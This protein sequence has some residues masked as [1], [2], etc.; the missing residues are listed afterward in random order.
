MPAPVKHQV[1]PLVGPKD[2][3]MTI[4]A[5]FVCNNGVL[6]CADSEHTD[7]ATKSNSAKVNTF[8]FEGGSVGYAYAG[9]DSLAISAIQTCQDKL[10]TCVDPK[11][12]V[13]ILRGA[14]EGEYRKHVLSHPSYSASSE[15]SYSLLLSVRNQDGVSL[16]RSHETALQKIE[17][18]DCIGVGAPFAR[19]LIQPNFAYRPPED[20]VLALAV[21]ALKLTKE[22]VPGCGGMSVFQMMK[23]DGCM[24]WITSESS[25][26]KPVEDF[27]E[28]YD[29]MSRELFIAMAD[30]N[31]DQEIFE[32]HLRERF[33]KRL[34]QIRKKW[35]DRKVRPGD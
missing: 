2:K 10:A 25:R 33:M 29:A 22:K 35:G 34:L 27:V 6:L 26:W 18:F 16:Y 8:K 7:W 28:E 5:G 3:Q 12:A 30:G 32:K 1:Y 19:Y 13:G 11:K 20:A 21:Y 23:T 31:V 17:T 9:N 15:L 4:A 14:L 24:Q